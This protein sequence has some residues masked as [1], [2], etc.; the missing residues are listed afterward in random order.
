[1]TYTTGIDIKEILRSTIV[2]KA[3]GIDDLSGRFLK[4]DSRV[5]SKPI[6][7]LCNLFIKLRRFTESCKIASLKSL[8]KSGSKTNPSNYR[9]ISLL[10]IIS[11]IIEKLIHEQTSSFSS[12]NEILYNYQSGFL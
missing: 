5:L 1:M 4:V 12:K 8:F 3:A 10:P 6:S 2:C 11:K 9:A 7:E